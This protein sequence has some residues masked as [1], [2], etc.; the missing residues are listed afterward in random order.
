MNGT[1]RKGGWKLNNYLRRLVKIIL[2]S[3][4]K[5]QISYWAETYNVINNIISPFVCCISIKRILASFEI[6]WT[7]FCYGDLRFTILNLVAE[8][9]KL[10]LCIL[11][12][13]YTNVLFYYCHLDLILPF[14]DLPVGLFDK[15]H[16]IPL[17]LLQV[18]KKPANII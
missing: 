10:I 3:P 11:K 4:E 13:F 9:S 7:R 1:S 15:H 16:I 8:Q 18:F 14:L 5:A 12:I 17:G 6:S 2:S